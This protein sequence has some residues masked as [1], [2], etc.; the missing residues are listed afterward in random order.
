MKML[1]KSLCKRPFIDEVID[2][3]PKKYTL[4]NLQDREN[5]TEYRKIRVKMIE[6]NEHAIINAEFDLLK[7]RLFQKNQNLHKNYI[8]MVKDLRFTKDKQKSPIIIQKPLKNI[9]VSKRK[10]SEKFNL[11]NR[12]TSVPKIRNLGSISKNKDQNYKKEIDLN[13]SFALAEEAILKSSK[14]TSQ[15]ERKKHNKGEQEASEN[16]GFHSN[17]KYRPHHQKSDSKFL[18]FFKTDE[19]HQNSFEEMM[20]LKSD[21]LRIKSELNDKFDYTDNIEQFKLNKNGTNI[22]CNANTC[23]S[24][25]KLETDSEI[26]NSNPLSLNRNS[27]HGGELNLQKTTIL[28][29]TSKNTGNQILLFE[30]NDKYYQYNKNK[31]KEKVKQN[32]QKLKKQDEETLQNNTSQLSNTQNQQNL[33][34]DNLN[35][36]LNFENKHPEE[37]RQI[38]SSPAKNKSKINFQGVKKVVIGNIDTKKQSNFF[39]QTVET[40]ETS[41][42]DLLFRNFN[43]QNLSAAEKQALREEKK[44]IIKHFIMNETTNTPNKATTS[45]ITHIPKAGKSE[46]RKTHKKGR[47]TL[48]LDPSQKNLLQFKNKKPV[49]TLAGDFQFPHTGRVNNLNPRVPISAHPPRD[50]PDF[51]VPKFNYLTAQENNNQNI[52]KINRIPMRKS[53]IQNQYCLNRNPN[54]LNHTHDSNDSDEGFR[55]PKIN[56]ISNNIKNLNNMMIIQKHSKPNQ[57][58]EYKG[59]QTTHASKAYLEDSEIWK[60]SRL[61]DHDKIGMKNELVGIRDVRKMESDFEWGSKYNLNNNEFDEKSRNQKVLPTLSSIHAPKQHHGKQQANLNIKNVK[62][63]ERIIKQE[64]HSKKNRM[65]DMNE[66]CLKEGMKD[67]EKEKGEA[68]YRSTG[69]VTLTAKR[70]VLIPN[71]NININMNVNTNMNMNVNPQKPEHSPNNKNYLY[72]FYSHFG[73]APFP[74]THKHN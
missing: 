18:P 65:H 23:F 55:E 28:P 49:L 43:G 3:L 1:E 26:H 29:L 19:I 57:K 46:E 7:N 14:V 37:R 15:K 73:T 67:L 51:T 13:E 40:N 60:N 10:A 48:S 56:N 6:T 35:S 71:M 17:S 21:N 33:D 59:S 45:K 44:K 42:E 2:M 32:Q 74:N 53:R 63:H 38:E 34:N 16:Q 52:P 5:Y 66:S 70:P 61:P 20:N 72:Y 27:K 30:K 62:F 25:R 22:N 36:S 9:R 50:D 54:L 24:T 11:V 31:F 58:K 68:K 39:W 12:S 4:T 41:Q 64:Q 8:S 69:E 47:E